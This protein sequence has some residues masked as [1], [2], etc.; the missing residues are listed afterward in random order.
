[1]SRSVLSSSRNGLAIFRSRDSFCSDLF[2]LAES[3]Q[4]SGWAER[5]SSSSICFCR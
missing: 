4:K 5:F 1:M 3:F 2:A